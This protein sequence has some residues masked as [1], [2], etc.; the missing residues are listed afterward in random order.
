MSLGTE[1]DARQLAP[2]KPKP[3]KTKK[4]PVVSINPNSKKVP[5]LCS[6]YVYLSPEEYA[7]IVKVTPQIV[8][9]M[10]RGGSIEGAFKFG[11]LWKIPYK[12]VG[13]SVVKNRNI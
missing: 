12:T 4:A 5:I 3:R 7:E 9:A 13:D 8:C 10:C 1:V 2:L 6:D 11:R